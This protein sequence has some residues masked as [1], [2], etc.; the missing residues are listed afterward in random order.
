[1]YSKNTEPVLSNSLV[2]ES[3]LKAFGVLFGFVICLIG[4]TARLVFETNSLGWYLFVSLVFLSCAMWKPFVLRIPY[5]MWL[6]FAIALGKLNSRLILGLFFC[7]VFI[8]IGLVRR[9]RKVDPLCR[10]W[11]ESALT[12]RTR[13]SSSE[14]NQ[15]DM[16]F[17]Y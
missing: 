15:Y 2:R 10:Q 7:I 12:Y 13:K 3:D 5:K 4:V 1:M 17:P 14:D 8:P 11:D 9:A 6:G 16:R